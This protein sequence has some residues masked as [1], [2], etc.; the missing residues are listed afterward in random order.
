MNETGQK[1]WKS[2]SADRRS[3]L[4]RRRKRF[5]S[6]K[7]LLNYHRRHYVRRKDDFQKIIVFDTYSNG[8]AWIVA[9]ILLLSLGDAFFTLYLTSIG[10]T[11]SNPIMAYYLSLGEFTFVFV[12]YGLTILS[13]GVVVILPYAIIRYLHMPVRHLLGC[14]I[15]VFALVVAWEIYLINS[16]RLMG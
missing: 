4:D 6:L 13:V 16:H 12:K 3:G 9:A 10:A 1:P 15:A 2:G 7:D 11:E 8:L 14:F 5:P